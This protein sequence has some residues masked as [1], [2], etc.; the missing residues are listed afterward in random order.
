MYRVLSPPLLLLIRLSLCPERHRLKG[1]KE[2]CNAKENS[3]T[4]HNFPL[5][6]FL[7]NF[8]WLLQF[9]H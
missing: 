5:D 3:S 1:F 7:M 9:K 4:G 2:N 6:R 8:K